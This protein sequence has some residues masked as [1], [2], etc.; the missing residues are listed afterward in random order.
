MEFFDPEQTDL[1]QL[2]GQLRDRVG[3]LVAGAIVGR[4]RLRDAVVQ[5]LGCS[6]L[7]AEQLVDTMVG[8]GFLI[9]ELQSDG[10]VAWAF[11]ER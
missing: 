1:A 6:E 8:R 9:K 2:A 7:Q 11:G 5:L 4:T 10:R 3:P